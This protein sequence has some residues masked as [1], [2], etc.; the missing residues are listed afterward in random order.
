MNEMATSTQVRRQLCPLF[1]MAFS[2]TIGHDVSM[3]KLSPPGRE[4]GPRGLPGLR[5]VDHIGFTVPDIEA[6]H[7]FLVDVLGCIHVYSLGPFPADPELMREKLGV[8]PDAV[9]EEIRFYR[10]VT[11]ANFEVFQ[12]S[13]P[14][15]R[16]R[17]PMNSDIGGHHVALYVD[18][19]DVAV[20]HLRAHG[21]EIMDE[22]TA[23]GGASAGQRWV[24]FRAPWGMQFELVSFPKGKA[25]E[26]DAE[27]LLWDTRNA[28]GRPQEPGRR[29]PQ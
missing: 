27:V 12:Y 17:P 7:D 22:P 9:M 14:G 13:A 21:V 5:G 10:C 29:A 25:Y 26:A 15:Q 3:N 8:R 20:A 18:D 2:I 28:D 16:C 6:A 4:D 24:Y 19:L 23:S 11:G 1:L